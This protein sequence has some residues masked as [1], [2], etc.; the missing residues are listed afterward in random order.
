MKK[1]MG[2]SKEQTIKNR[3]DK[4]DK[5]RRLVVIP[6]VKGVSEAIERIFRKHNI[7]TAMR[8]HMSLR[9]LHVHPKDKRSP[10]DTSGELY[11]ISCKESN[12]L[13]VEETGRQFGV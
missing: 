13:Y 4:K 2:R 11:S 7:S 12:R 5:S 1:Q 8:L 10:A 3:K 9:K 6:Y